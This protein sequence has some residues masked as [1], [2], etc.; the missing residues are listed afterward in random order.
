MELTAQQALAAGLINRIVPAAGLEAKALRFARDLDANSATSNA[1]IKILLR[2][3]DDLSLDWQLDEERTNFLKCAEV[4][5]FAKWD[6]A[7]LEKRAPAVWRLVLGLLFGQDRCDQRRDHR[8]P[9]QSRRI[10]VRCENQANVAREVEPVQ[11]DTHDTRSGKA[12]GHDRH[13]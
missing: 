8:R 9:C 7:F 13:A 4:P 10:D 11:M 12:I 3:S 5:D 1:A 2:A 6:A